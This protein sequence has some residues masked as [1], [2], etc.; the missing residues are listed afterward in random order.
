MQCRLPQ[1]YGGSS[2][3]GGTPTELT[4]KITGNPRSDYGYVTISGKKYSSTATVSIVPSTEIA[5]Y[6]GH[7][8]W[9]DG[10][11]IKLNGTTVQ[12]GTG[13]YKFVPQNSC[14]I[15]FTYTSGP[16]GNYCQ[17]SITTS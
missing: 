3:G 1:R 15:D 11:G 9:W 12:S 2:G 16:Y 7:G 10:S 8:G 13:E 6:V 5:V 17:A 14:T 4:V